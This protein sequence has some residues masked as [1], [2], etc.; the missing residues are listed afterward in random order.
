MGSAS[1][2]R[3]PRPVGHPQGHLRRRPGLHDAGDQE[4]GEAGHDHETV[5]DGNDVVGPP[6]P[7]AESA[8]V[9]GQ[10][11]RVP[12]PLRPDR[13]ARAHHGVAQPPQ[14]AEGV[15]HDLEAHLALHVGSGVLPVAPAATLG[16]EG[17][18]RIDAAGGALEDGGEPTEGVALVPHLDG[19]PL[20][21]KG[22]VDEHDAAVGVATERRP[23]GHHPLRLHLDHLAH[24]R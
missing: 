17:A 24:G 9:H 8:V 22:A 18:R 1:S 15:G 6:G 16:D 23:P 7:K 20:A 11:Q 21:R 2:S 4:L 19:Q 12:G 10:A 5:V 13:R 14:P 3:S